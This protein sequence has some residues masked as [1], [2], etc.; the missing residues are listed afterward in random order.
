MEGFHAE[1]TAM[2]YRLLRLPPALRSLKSISFSSCYPNDKA[3]DYQ[4]NGFYIKLKNTSNAH[5]CSDQLSLH[6]LFFINVTKF[7]HF[8]RYFNFPPLHC[9]NWL[10][11]I[12][13]LP[14]ITWYK[15]FCRYFNFP[16]LPKLIIL[17]NLFVINVIK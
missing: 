10:S 13:Y 14:S 9:P 5:Y 6:N 17:Y 2:L 3:L 8:G 11:C 16:L 12:I 4:M 1:I 15:I 7:K